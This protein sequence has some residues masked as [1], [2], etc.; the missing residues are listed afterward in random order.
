[1]GFEGI[2]VSDYVAVD[3]LVDPFCVADSFEEAG[4]LAI[5]AGLDVEYPR[6]KGFTYRMK[7][8]VDAGELSMGVIDRAVERVLKLKFELGLFEDPYPH[9]GELKKEEGFL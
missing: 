2:V 9:I 7:E 4:K 3:R 8:A 6:P 5:Q 1:M